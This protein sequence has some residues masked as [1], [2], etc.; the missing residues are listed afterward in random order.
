MGHITILIVDDSPAIRDG[1]RA[2]LDAHED[3]EV[4]GTASDGAEAVDL[5]RSARPAVVLMDAQMPIMDGAEATRRI[6]AADPSVRVIVLT[7]HAGH[8]QPGLDAGADAALL[9]DVPRADLL[10]V[11]RAI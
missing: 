3:L 8:L 4:V 10:R 11:I 7:V 9:K 5:V 1:L 2:I 6:K